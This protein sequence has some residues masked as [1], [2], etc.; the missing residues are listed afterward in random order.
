MII[1]QATLDDIPALSKMASDVYKRTFGPD[2]IFPPDLSMS[3]AEIS[4]QINK[5]KSEEAFHHAMT[6][7]DDMFL[8]AEHKNQIIGYIGIRNPDID[9]I[10][11]R[12]P[13]D[14]DQATNGIYV[15]P[16]FHRQGIGKKLLDAA[17]NEPRLQN[18]ENIYAVVWEENKPSFNLFTNNE[19]KIV[20]TK[21]VTAGSKLIGYDKV[22]MK[23]N[24]E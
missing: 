14:K 15:H 21:A 16:D 7:N 9:V 4:E 2:G 13:T 11:G 17:L 23:S 18:A 6:V 12:H 20:G 5:H 19:F 22:L 8:I 10:D 1:R 3:E 24:T